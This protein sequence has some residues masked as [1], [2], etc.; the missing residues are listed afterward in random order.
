MTSPIDMM[1]DR[2]DWRCTVCKEKAGTCDCWV[3]CDCGRSYLSGEEC[4][5]DIHRCTR[6]RGGM[7]CA[8]RVGHEEPHTYVEEDERDNDEATS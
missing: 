1:L 4:N 7:R 3:A 8:F 6:K 5:D 2:F